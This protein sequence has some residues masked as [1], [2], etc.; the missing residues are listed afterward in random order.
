MIMISVSAGTGGSD[1]HHADII[2]K[3]QLSLSAVALPVSGLMAF[4]LLCASRLLRY[5]F[6]SLNTRLVTTFVAQHC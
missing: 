6:E 3:T 4:F 5:L 1:E 2:I